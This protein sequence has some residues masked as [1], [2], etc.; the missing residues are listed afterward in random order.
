MGVGM[1]TLYQNNFP[2]SIIE[3]FVKEQLQTQLAQKDKKIDIP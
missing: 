2:C 3:K 1:S